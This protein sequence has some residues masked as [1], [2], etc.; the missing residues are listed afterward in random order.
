MDA[1]TATETRPAEPALSPSTTPRRS[2]PRLL[3]LLLAAG[4]LLLGGALLLLVGVELGLRGFFAVKDA[5]SPL[6]VPDLR[7]VQAGYDG[8]DWVPALYDEQESLQAE[9]APYSGFRLKPFD[10]RFIH[11]NQNSERETWKA[12]GLSP[13]DPE[14]LFLGGSSAW[15]LG[16]RDEQTIPSHVARDLDQAGHRA[17]VI[18]AAQVGHVQ[19]QELVE[20]LKRLQ[21]GDR[22]RV[23]VFYDGVNDVLAALQ[24]GRAGGPQNASNRQAEFNLLAKPAPF[25]GHFVVATARGSALARL[26]GSAALRLGI[27]QG[28]KTSLAQP[29]DAALAQQVMARCV[30]NMGLIDALAKQFDFEAICCWQPVLFT[31]RQMT[32]YEREKAAQYAWLEQPLALT[33]KR[34]DKLAAAE[35]SRVH[36]L[37]LTAIV[38]DE[39]GLLYVDF[40]HT[41]ESPDARIGRAIAREVANRLATP[42]S[43]ESESP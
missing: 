26:A 29:F 17:Q 1:T 4:W 3:L 16:A 10:G 21:A 43:N 15:G 5:I 39:P 12:D 24:S 11:V 41:T 13:Q 30:S 6:P 27:K 20:L 36:F 33:R 22:P 18:N 32:D 9:W 35:T 28:T 14:I 23:V 37:D 2:P 31:K 42:S 34:L 8:A 7:V 19:T 40:C 38:D 25:V